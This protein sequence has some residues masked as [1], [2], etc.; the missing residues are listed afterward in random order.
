[1]FYTTL[2][3][4]CLTGISD[5]NEDEATI[6]IR[7]FPK[8]FYENH[9]IFKISHFQLMTFAYLCPKCKKK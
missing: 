6:E 3:E 1:M 2:Q 8:E 9:F 7:Q 4:T 5:G